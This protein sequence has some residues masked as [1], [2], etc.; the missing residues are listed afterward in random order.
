MNIG[1][2]IA[3]IR[4]LARTM[5]GESWTDIDLMLRQS[6]LPTSSA[7]DGDDR[8][9]YC[10]EMLQ[11]GRDD[12][13]VDLDTYLHGPTDASPDDA[14]WRT[15][16]LRLFLSHSSRH[17]AG[18]AQLKRALAH[19]GIE[20]FVAHEDIQPNREW[21][22]VIEAALRSCDGCVALLHREFPASNWC[23]QEVGFALC[24]NVPVVPVQFGRQPYGF[25]GKVQSLPGTDVKPDD[26]ARRVARSLLLDPRTGASLTDRMVHQFVCAHSFGQANTLSTLLAVDAPRITADQMATLRAAQKVNRQVASAWHVEGNLTVIE[27]K[28]TL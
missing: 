28:F 7:W 11:H 10:V 3:L 12:V 15:P 14:P 13:L 9:R 26:L 1:R 6:G 19:Y 8:Y 17:N 4:K 20:G 2:R 24:R 22:R 16:D 27:K 21:Q 5:S 23:D 18:A 25:L